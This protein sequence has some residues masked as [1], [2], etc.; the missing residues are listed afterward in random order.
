MGVFRVWIFFTP[1]SSSYFTLL[2]FSGHL[3]WVLLFDLCMN[4]NGLLI[5]RQCRP[6]QAPQAHLG[7]I[8]PLRHHKPIQEPQ[9]H[10]GTLGLIQAH[11]DFFQAHLGMTSP[12]RQLRST[13]AP[14]VHLGT[15]GLIQAHFDFFKAHLG[16]ISPL[17][18]TSLAQV[19][20]Q[21]GLHG[22]YDQHV[23]D[24]LILFTYLF[25]S[26][27]HLLIHF[28]GKLHEN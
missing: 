8:G 4:Y 25:I 17:S 24:F 27:I 6:I 7:S 19:T 15:L 9:A 12:L 13:Q 5:I 1:C 11:F 18:F 22:L 2:I 16:M 20:F 26:F 10:L 14:Q 21:V 23:P 3:F 28:F